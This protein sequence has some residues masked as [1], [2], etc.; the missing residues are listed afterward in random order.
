MGAFLTKK[1]SLSVIGR[2]EEQQVERVSLIQ[3]YEPS[4]Q[5]EIYERMVA[6]L[7]NEV[8]TRCDDTDSVLSCQST[9]MLCD[10][11]GFTSMTETF[12]QRGV[13][14]IAGTW[15]ARHS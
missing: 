14:G 9:V 12:S 7:P 3:T 13:A 11:S 1:M 4:K 5:Q 6:F 15:R 8:R 2:R 10:I